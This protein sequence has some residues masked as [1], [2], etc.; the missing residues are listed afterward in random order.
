ML[1]KNISL[2]LEKL[3]ESERILHLNIDRLIKDS[4]DN[5]YLIKDILDIIVLSVKQDATPDILRRV[6]Q[7]I[8]LTAR[9]DKLIGEMPS[10]EPYHV[11]DDE[12]PTSYS[13]EDI[14]EFVEKIKHIIHNSTYA[15]SYL[16]IPKAQISHFLTENEDFK[17]EKGVLSISRPVNPAEKQQ[18]LELSIN[19]DQRIEI[20]KFSHRSQLLF[21]IYRELSW[22]LKNFFKSK[23]VEFISNNGNSLKYEYITAPEKL[24]EL[25]HM[26]TGIGAVQGMDIPLFKG[27]VIKDNILK[28]VKLS[29]VQLAKLME[30][31]VDDWQK[32]QPEFIAT[33]QEFSSYLATINSV[34]SEFKLSR[35]DIKILEQNVFQKSSFL[36]FIEGRKN[37]ELISYQ[38]RFRSMQDFVSPHTEANRKLR[39]KV[40][41]LLM[42]IFNYKYIYQV[43]LIVGNSLYGRRLCKKN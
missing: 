36:E 4:P 31:W 40:T 26:L 19:E 37:R 2:N 3:S 38:Q 15:E 9:S 42:S 13:V 28:Y 39:K 27:V 11:I 6:K 16:R 32:E 10:Q 20:M 22:A 30:P 8:N 12:G 5:E 17:Y 24:L 14:E 34:N 43:P 33:L 29:E 41:R 18:L 25:T 7:I 35:T 21:R 1:A 23:Y